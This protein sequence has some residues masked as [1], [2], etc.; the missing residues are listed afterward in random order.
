MVF[1][2]LFGMRTIFKEEMVID[3]SINDFSYDRQLLQLVK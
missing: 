3:K 1:E 2:I